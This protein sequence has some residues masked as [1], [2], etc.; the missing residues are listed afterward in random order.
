[1]EKSFKILNEPEYAKNLNETLK[2]SLIK[3]Q[4]KAVWLKKTESFLSEVPNKHSVKDLSNEQ[5]RAFTDDLAVINNLHVKNKNNYEFN[6]KDID[7]YLKYGIVYKYC[8][9][10]Y[11]FDIISL[12]K[13]GAI[14]KI[15]KLFGIQIYKH[16]RRN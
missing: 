5:D 10:K 4:S 11:I 12:K 3:H 9:I 6:K 1:M 7:L 16:T 8:G 13:H 2:N 15:I 14:T